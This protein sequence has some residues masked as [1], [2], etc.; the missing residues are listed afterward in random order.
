MFCK[1]VSN[2]KN[3]VDLEVSKK[4]LSIP[5][6]MIIGL[7][8]IIGQGLAYFFNL[9]T[10]FQ[11]IN[12]GVSQCNEKIERLASNTDDR[13]KKLEDA[14]KDLQKEQSKSSAQNARIEALLEELLK[15][16]R[17]KK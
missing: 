6:I 14:L 17:G 9:G 12:I 3:S 8:I 5:Y 11:M 10:K 4:T 16:K 15:E 13:I 1:C 7:I 2:L